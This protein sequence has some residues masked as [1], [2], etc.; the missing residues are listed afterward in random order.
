MTDD[1]PPLD[2]ENIAA[3]EFREGFG[4][5]LQRVLNLDTWS[6]GSDLGEIYRRVNDEVQA[7][8]QQEN[9]A[10]EGIRKEIFPR[11]ARYPNAPNGAGVYR[12]A[13]QD[14]ERIHR[15]LLFNG[16]VEA[17]DATIQSCDTLPLT[18]FQIGACLVSYRGNQGNWALSLFR[19]DLRARDDDPVE[20]LFDLLKRR[21]RRDGLNRLS[22]D[23]LSRLARRGIMAYAERAILLEKSTATWR[24]GHGNPAPFELLTGSG[25]PELM[26]EST[27]RIRTLVEAHK[28]FLFVASEPNE[29]VLLSIGQALQ[30][31]EYA[32]VRT[33][34]DD[35][36]KTVETATFPGVVA[37]DTS[38][39]G[40]SLSPATWIRRFRDVVGPQI[41]VG[42][43]R[44]TGLAPAH[45]FY[46][47]VDHAD[48]AAHI[49]LADSLLQEHRGFPL[50]I[51]LADTVCR[52][53]FGRES[54][55]APVQA[56]YADAG[57]PWRFLS[58]RATRNMRD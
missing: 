19:R 50:L 18:I 48:L 40:V 23:Q 12:A 42:V 21:E 28:K 26:V 46:A 7:A 6:L 27:R 34:Q 9:A 30:P 13:L 3:D 49:A 38:W 31:L 2:Q 32:I 29:R 45:V 39:D 54:L 51:D 55:E 44:A 52:S 35:I 16:G 58:E 11:L 10:C 37:A 15:G 47:H 22:R 41:V 1:M 4:E 5:D 24:L 56:A 57:A 53:M 36:N 20:A 33:L 25:S 17:C 8:V 43:Y 14:L